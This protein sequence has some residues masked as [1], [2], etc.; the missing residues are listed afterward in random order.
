[1]TTLQ[2]KQDSVSKRARELFVSGFHCSESVL[3]A[4]A[5]FKGI[6]SDLIPKIATG[7]GGG[8][9]RTCGMCGALSGAI[10]GI[11]LVAGRMTPTESSE[12]NYSLVQTLLKRF[13]E[14]NGSLNCRDLL[15]CDL[16]TEEG[17][18][19]FKDNHLRDKC[20]QLVGDAASL[21]VSLIEK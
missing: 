7:F 20:T 15:G 10:M 3:L 8:V 9:S 5:E 11:N 4:F 17:Q 21:A 12:H 18:R 16:G 19:S 2:E 13:A 6:H 14:K 1:M